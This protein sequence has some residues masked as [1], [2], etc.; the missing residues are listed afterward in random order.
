MKYVLVYCPGAIVATL[1]WL[2]ASL[3]F[4]FYVANFTDYNAAYGAIGG[5]MI[6]PLWFYISGL[7]LLA[8]AE[9]NAEIEHASQHGRIPARR[10]RARNG[11]LAGSQRRTM[12]SVNFD[13]RRRPRPKWRQR[14]R[15]TWLAHSPRS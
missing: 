11:S 8:G 15:S 12:S 13:S 9:M 1:L 10:C 3:A 7:A 2:I 4:K 6:L 5:V 14:W